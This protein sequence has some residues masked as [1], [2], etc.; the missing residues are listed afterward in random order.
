MGFRTWLQ[1]LLIKTYQKIV[2]EDLLIDILTF[3]WHLYNHR[4]KVRFQGR[5]ANHLDVIKDWKITKASSQD[6]LSS[7]ASQKHR[8]NLPPIQRPITDR[9]TGHKIFCAWLKRKQRNKNIFGG[10]HF[11]SNIPI[12][13]CYLC[14]DTTT[15]ILNTAISGLRKLVEALQAK[16]YQDLTIFCPSSLLHNGKIRQV[17]HNIEILLLDIIASVNNINQGWKLV[18]YPN[19]I[20]LD[21]LFRTITDFVYGFHCFL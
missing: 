3:A 8:N 9:Y 2:S 17:G 5:N 15:S 11:S 12:L 14:E 16:G 21:S 19:G 4:N 7:I 6:G 13:D 10:F 18:D 1:D 20:N